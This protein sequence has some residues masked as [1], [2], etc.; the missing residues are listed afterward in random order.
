MLTDSRCSIWLEGKNGLNYWCIFDWCRP[1][2]KKCGP[3]CRFDGGVWNALDVC[4]TSVAT[5]MH[6]QTCAVRRVRLLCTTFFRYEKEE[7]CNVHE[8]S[9]KL[10]NEI[11]HLFF[12]DFTKLHTPSSPERKTNIS[13]HNQAL[14]LRGFN[15]KSVSGKRMTN[16][17]RV[18][19][20]L[21][22]ASKV[23]LPKAKQTHTHT[24]T[25]SSS[26]L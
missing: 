12:S 25:H 26:C 17:P 13:S 8:R 3:V 9:F 2:S 5:A 14:V 10:W 24:L 21:H 7:G 1:I 20:L 4:S 6:H 11:R 23:T 18:H 16:G 22:F 15:N 19:T